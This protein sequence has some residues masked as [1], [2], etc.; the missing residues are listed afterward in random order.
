[1]SGETYAGNTETVA[2]GWGTTDVINIP[3]IGSI[4]FDPSTILLKTSLV[5]VS[6][7]VCDAAMGGRILDGMIC[8]SADNTDTCQVIFVKLTMIC[9]M[10]TSYRVT[11][12]GPCLAGH[13]QGDPI[14][15]WVSPRGVMAALYLA[16]TGCTPGCQ[17]IWTGWPGRWA[18]QG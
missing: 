5:P 10:L 18:S 15:W 1:M 17:S 7:S 16:H 12:E 3:G 8:A 11:V 13:H 4:S 9:M 6:N 14:A 2:T